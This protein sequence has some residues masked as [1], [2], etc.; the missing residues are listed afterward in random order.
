MKSVAVPLAFAALALTSPLASSAADPLAP[1]P[2]GMAVDRPSNHILIGA[3]IH[4]S[5]TETYESENNPALLIENG[6]IVGVFKSANT[7]RI[8][9][10]Y[11]IHQ[12]D[13]DQHI[14]PGFI[15]AFVEIDSPSIDASSAG[16]H[17]NSRV[18]P[19]RDV[20]SG[21]GL[22]DNKAKSLRELGFTTAMIAPDS[23]VLRGWTATVSTASDYS[24]PSLGA[25]PIYQHRSGQMLG[26]DRSGWQEGTYPTSHMGVIALMRQSFLDA[27]NSEDPSCLTNIAS[28]DTTLF[29]DT[30]HELEANLAGKIAEEFDHKNVVIIGSGSEHRRLDAIASMGFPVVTPLTFPKD[31]DVW[32]VNDAD[33]VTLASLQHWERAPA[34]ARWLNNSGVTVAL[35]SSKLRDDEKFIT[36]LHAAIKKGLP[37]SDALAMLTTNPAQILDLDNQGEIKNGNI[38]NFVVTSDDLFDPTAKAKILETWIDGRKH[39]INDPTNTTFDGTWTVTIPGAGMS[40]TMIIEDDSLTINDHAQDSTTKAS[41]YEATKDSFSFT[42]DYDNDEVG[43]YVSSATILPDGSL[44]GTSITPNN[45]L[46]Q[47]TAEK[48]DP[49]TTMSTFKGTWDATLA[50][51]FNLSFKVDKDSVTIIEHVEG[52]DDITQTASSAE[53]K[54]D[55]LNFTFDHTPFGMPGDFSIAL[56]APSDDDTLMGLGARP[57]GKAFDIVASKADDTDDTMEDD[58]DNQLPDL[59]DSPFGPYT[60]SEIPPQD[61][62]LITNATVW[63]QSDEGI[64]EDAWIIIRNGKIHSVGSGGYPRIAVD[65][66]IDA[67]GKHITPG[68]IDAHSHTGLFRFGVNE[69]GQA[70][71]A[72]VRIEDSLDP[73]YIGF[74]R[75]LAGGLTSAMLLHGS[76]NPIGGQSKTIKLRWGSDKPQDM[77]MQDAIPGIKFAL[78]EN[79]KQSNW[80]DDNTTRYPQTRMGVETTMRDRFT[81]ARE[82]ADRGMKTDEGNTDL[83]LQTLAEILAGDRLVHCHSYRQDEILMLCRIAEEFGFKI[84]TF[85]HGLETYKVAE[86]VKEHAIGASIFSDWW[87]YKVEVTDAIPYAG[88]INHEVGLLTSFNSDSDDVARRMNTEAAKALKYA[89]ASGIEMSEQDALAFVTTNPAIQ[90]GIIDRVGTLEAG[91]DADIVIWSGSPLSSLSRCE[92]TYVDG[93]KYFSLED[94]Q[95]HRD[96]I[97][98]ERTRLIQLVLTDGKPS[99][100]SDSDEHEH[101]HDHG[102]D[103]GQDETEFHDTR[104]DCGC[105]Q[106]LPA[107]STDY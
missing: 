28:K 105:N 9:P 22:P 39:H 47:W 80:G 15:D 83:E 66:T 95:T 35:T 4:L 19:Q 56:T 101:D 74:Y 55:T 30:S 99:T 93:R 71:T 106:L 7:I 32:T 72:E 100:K 44:R 92:A 67:Q 103:L 17:W 97:N 61:S 52:Q 98:A 3:T 48:T 24:D 73:G 6:T 69:T 77:Y 84:G 59:P 81:K 14:Y 89:R 87:A 27:S 53:I 5:P 31:P 41:K 75:E 8:K 64:L 63:T 50:S 11:Q 82:Y 12:L 46:V 107:W 10:G 94:D 58:E 26:F 60:L 88:P 36:N 18:T 2:N 25:T 79:V 40:L 45:A 37:A 102:H 29:Y 20:L 65:H 1:R 86:I 78:G 104:G 90:L 34:N 70:V 85:Q 13:P 38:A 43:A 42:I 62:V 54:N 21:P 96:A 51:K 23:G 16:V 91:K 33:S 76:A 57:D 68:L 49:A